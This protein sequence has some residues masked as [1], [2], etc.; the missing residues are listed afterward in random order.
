[1]TCLSKRFP[2]FSREAWLGWR[3][4]AGM[5]ML[6][7][8]IAIRG[9]TLAQSPGAVR[10]E[11]QTI[12]ADGDTTQQD[13][14]KVK[15]VQERTE[16]L[17]PNAL[18]DGRPVRQLATY[19]IQDVLYPDFL[20]R[21]GGF[22]STL[23]QWGKPYIRYKYG[24]DASNI[25]Q[26]IYINPVTGAENGY[27]LDPQYGMR[28]YDTRTPYV[29]A[30]YAQGRADA[31]QLRVDIAQNI[32]PLLNASIL[33][34][35]RQAN[36][37]YP[38][39]VTD[40]NTLGGS[41]NFHTLNGRYQVYAHYLFQEHNENINGGVLIQLPDSIQFGKGNQAVLLEDA[42]LG[43]I[44]NAA[45]Y[46][47]FYR[48]FRDTVD[49]RHQIHLYQGY[50]HEFIVNEYRD[51]DV[52]SVFNTGL[53]PVYPTI[54]DS[55]FFYEKMNYL[56]DKIDAG[57]T[58]RYSGSVLKSAQRVEASQ[59]YGVFRK[60]LR[61]TDIRRFSILWKGNLKYAPENREWEASWVYR[62]SFTNVFDP[63]SYAE[64]D[65]NY[66]FPRWQLDYSYRVAGSPLKPED[67]ATITKTH[68]PFGLK[69]HFLRHDRNPTLQ[70]AFGIGWPG[71]GLKPLADLSNRRVELLRLGFELRG[72]DQWTPS[73]V[74]QGNFFRVSAFASRQAGMIYFSASGWQRASM[75]ESAVYA[76]GE[77]H[78]R[79]HAGRIYLE[80]ET[81]FQGFS[82]A[83]RKLDTLFKLTQP[84]FYTK[85]GLFYEK[86]DLKFASLVRAGLDLWYFSSFNAPYFEPGS[87]SFYPQDTY[88]Q[89]MYPRLDLFF[90]VQIKRAYVFA[91]VLNLLEGVPQPGYF[92]TMGYPMP[93]RQLTL[94]LN[95]TFFD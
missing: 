14:P 43:R 78:L 37:V 86:K 31:V 92:T 91:K 62:Q 68:R 47:Q 87:Q 36:G 3:T 12:L 58:Y 34:L 95:W 84:N 81:V 40:Q 94:G 27:F 71:N 45:A 73:G 49:L 32:N 51:K 9:H 23:G 48:I 15:V 39:F 63:E 38:Q 55:S 30:S 26:G 22:S 93:V 53:Y 20:D 67:S 74:L 77:L 28:Y 69:L 11:G 65:L 90:A 8:N 35:R 24:T 82:S 52:G 85:T 56:R 16:W 2:C 66:R 18:M 6:F 29:N 61:T 1:M 42:K 21:A 72:K 41:A 59:E 89:S 79:V 83:S 88:L 5:M 10:G 64:I 50:V 4:L 60:N 44:S 46:R 33:Y 76:G 75:T 17:D 70:Q 80:S 13:S 54:G 57:V 25:D 19:R 7:L